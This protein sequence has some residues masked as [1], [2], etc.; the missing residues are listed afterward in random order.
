MSTIALGKTCII[1]ITMV[2]FKPVLTANLGL[3]PILVPL[4]LFYFISVVEKPEIHK[5]FS[6]FYRMYRLPSLLRTT[7]L[8]RRV[9]SPHFVAC[10]STSS[11]CNAKELKFGRDGRSAMLQG[12]EILAE[13]VAATL[14]PKVVQ[15]L[16]LNSLQ[17][18]FY[19]MS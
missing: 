17:P 18:V 2:F 15:L 9:L 5:I 1:A 19:I 6:C 7:Q 12:V 11:S 14:G 4:G 8:S 10:L 13:A 3:L 16:I